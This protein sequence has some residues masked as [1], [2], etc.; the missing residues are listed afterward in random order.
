MCSNWYG[1]KSWIRN[2][3]P[4]SPNFTFHANICT[5]CP[6]ILLTALMPHT[7]TKECHSTVCQYL[8]STQKIN[9]SNFLVDQKI[10]LSSWATMN[11]KICKNIWISDAITDFKNHHEKTSVIQMPL[12]WNLFYVF[13]KVFVSL[14]YP[15][16]TRFSVQWHIIC[17][18]HSKRYLSHRKSNHQSHHHHDIFSIEKSQFLVTYPLSF[19]NVS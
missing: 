5:E 15:W 17:W 1:M 16:L 14:T 9:P 6:S 11:S 4:L 18:Y 13:P 12:Q 19:Q 10:S 3:H 7:S 8:Y 2:L